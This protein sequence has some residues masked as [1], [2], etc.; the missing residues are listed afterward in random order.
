MIIKCPE[1][2]H[3]VSDK[4]P[5]CPNCGVEIAG[6]VVK[7]PHCGEIYL[8]DDDVCPNCH[9]GAVSSPD[10]Q[11]GENVPQEDNTPDRWQEDNKTDEPHDTT[12][13][14][15]ESPVSIATPIDEDY[16]HESENMATAIPNEEDEG[17]DNAQKPKEDREKKN[18]HISL[19]VSLAITVITCFVLLY[20]Y[21]DTKADNERKEFESAMQSKNPS[22]LQ[23]YIA[24]FE[25]SA[26]ADHIK[27]AVKL[28]SLLQDKSPDDW[29]EVV[30]Q[31]TR[32]AYAA[33]LKAHPGTPYESLIKDK[34]DDFDW[35]TACSVNTEDAYAR[36]IDQHPDGKHHE[37]AGKL[38]QMRMTDSE[39]KNE[40]D[41]AKYAEPVRRLLIAMNS[42]STEGI[43][44][45]VADKLMFNGAGGSTSKDIAQYMRDKLYQADVK[46]ITWKMEKPTAC[47]KTGS[48]D[49]KA[50]AYN[51]T[52]PA[53]LEINREGG[54]ATL[55]YIIK[56]TVN[57][58][59]RI[60]SISLNRQ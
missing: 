34:L 2:G 16:P 15:E 53:K 49:Q 32:A 27:E 24:D 56:A 12:P 48:E 36:Y 51:V 14:E 13:M 3:Q 17:I 28:L 8:D 40:A 43:S 52:I 47:E 31:N 29:A 22:V 25:Q 55:Q 10:M 33:Y 21:Q 41:A 42:K 18:K 6:H 54:K 50:I 59:E 60:T 58:Q 30:K 26:P 20:F 4:A 19:L 7:C 11:T 35:A 9:Q 5:V 44:R 39:K 45:A 23:Q 57:S 46:S 38:A 1:C 37:E